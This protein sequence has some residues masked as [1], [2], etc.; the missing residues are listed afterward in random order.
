MN[1][2]MPLVF[3]VAMVGMVS[4]SFRSPTPE[5]W[6]K[7]TE[8]KVSPGQLSPERL[9]QSYLIDKAMRLIK[10]AITNET[11]DSK[12]YTSIANT[13]TDAGKPKLAEQVMAIA[14]DEDRHHTQLEQIQIELVRG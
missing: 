8:S 14:H 3:M 6:A 10:E 1:M 4:S 5:K 7:S 2:M 11:I 9:Q 12:I 13:L